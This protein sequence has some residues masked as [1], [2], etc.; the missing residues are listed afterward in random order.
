MSRCRHKPVGGNLARIIFQMYS[1]IKSFDIVLINYEFQI[2]K[3]MLVSFI[4]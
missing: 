2:I 1:L 3:I 4:I